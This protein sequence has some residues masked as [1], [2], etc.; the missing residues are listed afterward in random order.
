MLWIVL[1][2]IVF[3][4]FSLKY[5]RSH[6]PRRIAGAGDARLRRARDDHPLRPVRPAGKKYRRIKTFSP[7]RGG[8]AEGLD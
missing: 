7:M 4:E 6:S 8:S 1:I 5:N 3:C 2:L